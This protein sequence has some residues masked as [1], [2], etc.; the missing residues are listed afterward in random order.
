M[1]QGVT[2][3][4]AGN[5]RALVGA[6][7]GTAQGWAREISTKGELDGEGTKL[8]ALEFWGGLEIQ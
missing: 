2:Q 5:A 6:V 4:V 8:K 7:W 3:E 1:G